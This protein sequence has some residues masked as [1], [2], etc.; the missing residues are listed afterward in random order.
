[1]TNIVVCGQ[2]V[3]ATAQDQA[4]VERQL[5]GGWPAD[6]DPAPRGFIRL[7]PSRT[8]ISIGHIVSISDIE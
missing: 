5:A 8:L 3:Q 7:Y 6:T 4:G 1:M 2:G